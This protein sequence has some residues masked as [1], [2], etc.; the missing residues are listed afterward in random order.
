MKRREERDEMGGSRCAEFIVIV[1][2]LGSQREGIRKVESVFIQGP[3]VSVSRT[4]IDHTWIHA[5]TSTPLEVELSNTVSF[6]LS[7]DGKVIAWGGG[8]ELA[9]EDDICTSAS[10]RKWRSPGSEAS[11][12]IVFEPSRPW[13]K[14]SS[15]STRDS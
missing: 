11:G 8:S 5:Y 15:T 9:A 1:R 6:K 12:T 10:K 2:R 14:L 3:T 7:N 4:G 13:L